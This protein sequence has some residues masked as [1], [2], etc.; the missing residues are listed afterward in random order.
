[1]KVYVLTHCAAERNYTPSVFTDKVAAEKEL[2]SQYEDAAIEQLDDG[3]GDFNDCVESV[4]V[5]ETRAEITYVDDT[6]DVWEIF[7]VEVK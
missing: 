3:G 2:M 4:E 7:E 5:T 6:Y 1:M